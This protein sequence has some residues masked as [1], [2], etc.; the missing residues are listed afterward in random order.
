M[1]EA[2]M[3]AALDEAEAAAEETQQDQP[4]D[5]DIAKAEE[6]FRLGEAQFLVV[7]AIDDY[8]NPG[9]DAYDAVLEVAKDGI[10]VM[11]K[12]S[13]EQMSSYSFVGEILSWM[14]SKRSFGLSIKGFGDVWFSTAEAKEILAA[15]QVSVTAILAE[16]E[17]QQ[18]A[19][20]AD[21]DRM[22]GAK[23]TLK[24]AEVTETSDAGGYTAYKITVTHAD[25]SYEVSTRYS[26][27]EAFLAKMKRSKVD[28]PKLPGKKMFGSKGAKVI[29]ERRVAINAI[30]QSCMASF[31]DHD[32]VMEFLAPKE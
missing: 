6:A 19:M 18:A 27:I 22:K 24:S 15:I 21:V 5:L 9:P 25:G 4:T 14:S 26:E 3:A 11:R 2:A 29:E 16:R 13:M 8:G 7:T 20:S 12:S 30:L 1:D 10:N 23:R 28:L 32:I 17:A 31:A